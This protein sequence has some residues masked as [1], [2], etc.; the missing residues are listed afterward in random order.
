M[1]ELQFVYYF[2]VSMAFLLKEYF[3]VGIFGNDFYSVVLQEKMAV[4]IA[5]Q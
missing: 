5:I 4:S 3:A 1:L 2:G